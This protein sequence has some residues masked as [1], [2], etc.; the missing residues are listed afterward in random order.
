MGADLVAVAPLLGALR[1]GFRCQMGHDFT[2]DETGQGLTLFTAG[3]ASRRARIGFRDACQNEQLEHSSDSFRS[4]HA[5]YAVYEAE[6]L[7]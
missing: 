5:L 3:Y 4:K 6:T 1:A 2:L 7:T